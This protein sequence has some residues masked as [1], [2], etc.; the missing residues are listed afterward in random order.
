M[1]TPLSISTGGQGRPVLIVS[2]EID[3]SNV[4]AF[5]GSLVDACAEVRHGLLTVDL[6]GVDYIDS[7]GINVLF[8]YAD[9]IELIA[10]PIL[11]PV[12]KISGL[13]DVVNIRSA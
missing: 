10:N 11:M 4:E 7:G 13:A 9:E 8:G 3:M 6:S 12:L 2:G 1:A 5:E